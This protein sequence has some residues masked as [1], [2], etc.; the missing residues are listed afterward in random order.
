M[1]QV[2]AVVW[3]WSLAQEL[4]H[5]T[6]I[7]KKNFPILISNMV[8]INRW[9]H[10]NKFSNIFKSIKWYSDQNVW[11]LL[12][13][14]VEWISA[15]EIQSIDE[16]QIQEMIYPEWFLLALQLWTQNDSIFLK[17]QSNISS[18]PKSPVCSRSWTKH[19]RYLSKCGQDS[20]RRRIHIQL[21][22]AS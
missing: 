8:N 3:V 13:Y 5:V 20:T 15:K 12:V 7:A 9:N 6:G 4:S 11:E 14:L 21:F 17:I 18:V 16:V 1:A 10:M 2:T 22:G 19:S